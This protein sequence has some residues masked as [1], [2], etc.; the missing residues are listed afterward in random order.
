MSSC[1]SRRTQIQSEMCPPAPAGGHIDV[2]TL[3]AL[4]VNVSDRGSNRG[5]DRARALPHQISIFF[6]FNSGSFS[7]RLYPKRTTTIHTHIHGGCSHP[8][9]QPARLEL[10]GVR[11][12]AHGDLDT[13]RTPNTHTQLGGAG[14]RTS[15]LPVISQDTL[16]PELSQSLK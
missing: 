10:S 5:F 2:Q 4:N 16:P 12:L 14:G 13:R 6:R 1:S 15:N 11:C 8:R 7:R 9:R 3:T